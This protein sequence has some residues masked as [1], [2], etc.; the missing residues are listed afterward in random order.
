[1]TPLLHCPTLIAGH[2]H[3]PAHI[4]AD[5]DGAVATAN[6]R[7]PGGLGLTPQAGNLFPQGAVL[8]QGTGDLFVQGLTQRLVIGQ[9]GDGLRYLLHV[10]LA[11]QFV[12]QGFGP[13]PAL[14]ADLFAHFLSRLVAHFEQVGQERHQ[15]RG[16]LL[17]QFP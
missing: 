11:A 6:N 9:G 17:R 14:T 13:I 1:M 12:S 2:N 3:A 4:P 7:H 5:R 16:D 10:L 15:K 8:L